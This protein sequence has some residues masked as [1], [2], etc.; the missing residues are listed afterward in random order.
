M[1]KKH[2]FFRMPSLYTCALS[3]LKEKKVVLDVHFICELLLTYRILQKLKIQHAVYKPQ[4]QPRLSLNVFGNRWNQIKLLFLLRFV[5]PLGRFPLT[6]CRDENGEGL[7]APS[8]Y[9]SCL[10]IPVL[11]TAPLDVEGSKSE[12]I[13]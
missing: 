7:E 1:T 3:K 9:Y 8:C 12:N 5:F 2:R 10:C 11:T 13:P 4:L 6:S